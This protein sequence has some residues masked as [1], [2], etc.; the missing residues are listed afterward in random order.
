MTVTLVDSRYQLIK[1]L[2][3]GA[4]GK[5]FL[6]QDLITSQLCAVKLLNAGEEN[7]E[8]LHEFFIREVN[9]LK[10]LQHPN[11]V[12]LQGYGYDKL[13][14]SNYLVLEFIDGNNLEE[15]ISG[16]AVSIDVSVKFIIQVLDALIY[17]HSKNIFH[18]DVKPSNILVD[19]AEN[20]KLAD[21][22]VSKVYHTLSKGMTVRNF[23]SIPYAAP[24]Q[25]Q[26]KPVGA[27]T[28]IYLVGAVF[29]KLITGQDPQSE[30]PLND[31]VA[32]SNI[33]ADLKSIL[34]KMVA[35]NIE[36]RFDSAT[37]ARNSLNSF[38]NQYKKKNI[39]H[40]LATTN[41]IVNELNKF[42]FT[43]ANDI[44]EACRF[45]ESELRGEV[46]VYYNPE[47]DSYE[48]IGRQIKLACRQDKRDGKHL[49]IVKCWVPSPI[50]LEKDRERGV[51][52]AFNWRVIQGYPPG[53]YNVRLFLD[54]LTT[55]RKEKDA[56]KILEIS[57]KDMI[58]QW[59]KVL[60]LERKLFADAQQT[61]G[62]KA[63]QLSNDRDY[64]ELN[65]GQADPSFMEDQILLVSK[66]GFNGYLTAGYYQE[67]EKRGDD[68]LIIIGL[69]R[70]ID[71]DLIADSG[72]V[73]ADNRQL[74]SALS[75][76]EKAIRALKYGET[77]N[78]NLGKLLLDPVLATVSKEILQIDKY[79]NANLDQSKKNA[80]NNAMLASDIFII[81]GPPGTGKT[82]L[83][84]ELVAQIIYK[85]KKSKI[86]ICSQ[87][88]IAV[89]HALMQI[90][91]VNPNLPMIRIG[92]KDK[93]SLGAEQFMFEHRIRLFAENTKLLSDSFMEEYKKNQN[94]SSDTLDAL[95]MF[96]DVKRKMALIRSLSE[97]KIMLE[98][99]LQ[100]TLNLEKLVNEKSIAITEM[101][102]TLIKATDSI[103]NRSNL[104]T[105]LESIVTEYILMGEEFF[106]I[107]NS[108]REII[109]NY[110][111]L[112]Q[113]LDQIN[114]TIFEFTKESTETCLL[115]ADEL[116]I[117]LDT[118]DINEIINLIQQKIIE[119]KDQVEKVAQIEH[120]RKEWLKRIEN[121][122]ELGEACVKE[123][124]V[125]AAT[126]LGIASN[127]TIHNLEFDYVII[128]EAG[129]ATPPETLVPA[130]RGK[131]IIM[132]GD[133]KQLPPMVDHALTND[134]LKEVNLTR[135]E[136]EFTIFEKL[137]LEA[138]EDVKCLLR[139]QYRMHPAIGKLISTSFYE[140]SLES[141][142]LESENN[143][144]L[145][146]W[147][148][149]IIWFSTSNLESRFEEKVGTSRQNSCEAKFIE[150]LLTDIEKQYRQ[151][152]QS[153]RVAVITGYLPQKNY[154]KS[155]IDPED[156][157]R[158][159]ALNIEVDT[160][161]AFQG[162]ETN[163]VIYSIVRSNK[164]N[165]IGFI[166]DH[167]RL[168]VALSRAK[169]LLIIVGDFIMVPKAKT[170]DG[171]N[172]FLPVANYITSHKDDCI[173]EVI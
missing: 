61:V 2:G 162:R 9:A 121:I 32:N 56:K 81:Q 12:S 156:I 111:I 113:N 19:H 64:L 90:S 104:Q 13:S 166:G 16:E 155:L 89:N 97:Q 76:Q 160:V 87:S 116:E 172:P 72:E 40:Y 170:F 30:T 88:N 140:S 108:N 128:D 154:L 5:V 149:T 142:T 139:E 169:E 79:F 115:L 33:E 141:K 123:A 75:R 167:R 65:I 158:W 171:L 100:E 92:R 131:K 51:N 120:I 22:G 91:R 35:I 59:E 10:R 168:N 119:S 93:M 96:E 161:D 31:L 54:E 85:N 107:I 122:E 145:K 34:S 42:G 150:E 82:T 25:I 49:V 44:Q 102:N 143:H 148:K 159:I 74:A 78:P 69:T 29:Y 101:G 127:P 63:K 144:E 70:D 151:L 129:R 21:F 14:Q 77:I 66:R 47:H 36:D 62:Y 152:G 37:Q 137:Y 118:S 15:Y 99:D 110:P 26:Q 24:E 20:I 60:D 124:A 46:S 28:D 84:S 165:D 138:P 112:K 94:I 1:T 146:W 95:A 58:G 67:I 8:Y 125:V 80:V 164:A 53:D 55:L 43:K 27:K 3:S 147:P 68:N 18:R 132:V 48:L 136:L 6:A 98:N 109:N 11:I 153:R 7:D 39:I 23:V 83:I 57:H 134:L 126:C 117:T 52:V 41:A 157:N 73:M 45:V 71:Y 86:M 38:F 173:I 106:E 135:K 105:A 50:N 130:V 4:T 133:Q 163:L 103:E 17:A 114:Q